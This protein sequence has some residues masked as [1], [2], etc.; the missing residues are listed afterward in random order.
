MRGR[1]PALIEEFGCGLLK[2]DGGNLREAC[3]VLREEWQNSV[4]SVLTDTD[5]DE[6]NRS[7]NNPAHRFNN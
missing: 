4:D 3:R 1:L 5:E 6:V 2:T 7:R